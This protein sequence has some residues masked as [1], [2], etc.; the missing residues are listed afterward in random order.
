[1]EVTTYTSRAHREGEWW[2]IQCDEAPGAISQVKR[3]NEAAVAQRE[4]IAFVLDVATSEVDVHLV[5]TIAPEIDAE[6][7]ELRDLRAEAAERETRAWQLS[8][9]LARQLKDEG[10]TV[11][12]VAVMLGV[13]PQ[14]VDQI[15]KPERATERKAAS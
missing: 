5:P 8:R 3:L 12:E 1:M 13:S 9:S 4:A 15:L 6:I 10:Y 7:A 2:I 11:R 14:R